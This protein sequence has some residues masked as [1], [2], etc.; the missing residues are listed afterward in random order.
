MFEHLEF[1]YH[2]VSLC[3]HG[4]Y[5]F[6]LENLKTLALP[7]LVKEKRIDRFLPQKLIPSDHQPPTHLHGP[8][9]LPTAGLKDI[10][11]LASDRALHVTWATGSTIHHVC[12]I[13]YQWCTFFLFSTWSLGTAGDDKSEV[14][15]AS[16]NGSNI[17]IWTIYLN[18]RKI[19]FIS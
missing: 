9:V 4:D 5:G 16:L 19:F 10:P 12:M 13:K 2:H 8:E 7:S 17:H 6:A 14:L 18:H 1:Q 3:L 11:L 15:R